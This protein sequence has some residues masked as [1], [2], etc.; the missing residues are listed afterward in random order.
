MSKSFLIAKRAPDPQL[1]RIVRDGDEAA[2]N[3]P[4]LWIGDK[5]AF[6]RFQRQHKAALLDAPQEQ[7]LVVAMQTLVKFDEIPTVGGYVTRVTGD[8]RYPFRF[9]SDPARFAP[10]ATEG[11]IVVEP[12]GRR[13]LTFRVPPGGDPSR[14][15]RIGVPGRGETFGAM[16]FYI[17]EA[18]TDWLW[19][20][21]GLAA[22]YQASRVRT[23]DQLLRTAAQ[24]HGQLL[25]S[26]ELDEA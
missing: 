24:N 10:W 6:S 5:A 17:P 23:I 13:R 14:H 2:G 16:T 9:R 25:S 15:Q 8:A 18:T 12:N 22:G 26:A 20:H 3:L 4:R 21:D 1:W 7:R 19:T 11:S